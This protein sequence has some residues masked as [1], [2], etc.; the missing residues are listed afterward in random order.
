MQQIEERSIFLR[1]LDY[2]S[3]SDSPLSLIHP[4]SAIKIMN[5]SFQDRQRRCFDLLFCI[6]LL[7]SRATAFSTPIVRLRQPASPLYSS[8][9]DEIGVGIDLGTTFSAVAILEGNFPDIISVPNNGRTMPSVVAFDQDGKP[10]VGREAMEWEESH[11]TSAYRN[12]KRVIGIGA[13]HISLE[14]TKVVPHLVPFVRPETNTKFKKKITLLKQLQDAEENPAML[15]SLNN[16]DR[17][18]TISPVTVSS[19]ILQKLLETATSTT[20]KKITRAVIGVPAY[21]ND[22]Q[23]EATV[24]AANLAGISK[25]KLLREPEAVRTV[26]LV[27]PASIR[28]QAKLLSLFHCRQLLLMESIKIQTG[29]N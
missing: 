21:F 14:T 6:S 16:P 19:M 1:H 17:G 4:K 29:K 5:L 23:R 25:V 12:I 22:A 13:N 15:Y 28:V 11:K 26:N 9:E 18:A 24:K 10:L 8:S 7:V 3:D 2:H 20:Q 27:R